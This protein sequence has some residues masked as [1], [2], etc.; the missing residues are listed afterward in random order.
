[1]ATGIPHTS[2]LIYSSFVC[3][4]LLWFTPNDISY[5]V[6]DTQDA[7]IPKGSS[8]RRASVDTC[9]SFPAGDKYQ[10]GNIYLAI[11]AAYNRLAH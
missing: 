6:S 3:K 5:Q 2:V 11:N 9:S 8:M 10:T 4:S 1:M 7:Q